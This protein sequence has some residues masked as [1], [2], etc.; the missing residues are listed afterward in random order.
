M[1]TPRTANSVVSPVISETKSPSGNLSVIIP[2][3]AISSPTAVV[4]GPATSSDPR[5]PQQ[6]EDEKK[7]SGCW[8]RCLSGVSSMYIAVKENVFSFY[9]PAEPLKTKCGKFGFYAHRMATTLV[10]SSVFIFASR[11]YKDEYN[12]QLPNDYKFI[13]IDTMIGQIMFQGALNGLALIAAISMQKSLLSNELRREATAVWKRL[14]ALN[15][16]TNTLTNTI[17]PMSIQAIG[18]AAQVRALEEENAELKAEVAAL[19]GKSA[20]QN[21]ETCHMQEGLQRMQERIGRMEEESK[22]NSA[23]IM[24]MK[25]WPKPKKGGVP[26]RHLFYKSSNTIPTAAA[27]APA[28]IKTSEPDSKPKDKNDRAKQRTCI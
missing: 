26:K 4:K 15:N 7:R 3:P 17:L 25:K 8:G 5:K 22:K 1:S 2:M 24:A 6:E 10:S 19:K 14:K 12:N 13:S 21:I 20:A 11:G 28:E 9:P 16:Q 27:A 23:K 18:L